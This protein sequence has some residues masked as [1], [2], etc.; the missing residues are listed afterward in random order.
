MSF[1]DTITYKKDFLKEK[2]CAI[3]HPFLKPI[4]NEGDGTVSKFSYLKWREGC[5]IYGL[6]SNLS[7]CHI[8]L[9]HYYFGLARFGETFTMTS[10]EYYYSN[11]EQI[12]LH[13]KKIGDT[14]LPQPERLNSDIFVKILEATGYNK[15][16]FFS[17][18]KQVGSSELEKSKIIEIYDTFSAWEIESLDG[19]FYLKNYP[20]DVVTLVSYNDCFRLDNLFSS[21]KNEIDIT[22]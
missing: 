2:N 17:M 9:L 5:K 1:L 11:I 18:Y 7:D 13:L 4:F 6:P 14:F 20:D 15:F 19:N 22:F 8:A 16:N 3:Y 12:Y 10:E 21:L